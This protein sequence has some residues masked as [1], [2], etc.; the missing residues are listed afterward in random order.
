MSERSLIGP[1]TVMAVGTVT[2]RVTGVLRDITMAAALGFFLVSDAFSLG[3]SLPT[4]IYILVIGG[5]LNAV[6]IPQLVRKMKD[7]ADD[8]K[9]YADRLITITGIALLVLSVMAVVLA[10]LIVDLYT[11]SDYPRQEFDLAVAFARLCLPQIFFYGVYAMLS[12]VL[13]SRGKFGAPM[14]A[15]IANN[16]VAI[17]TFL[18]F[19][20]I[21]GTSAAADGVLTT[22]QVLLLGIGTTLGVV[23]QALILIPVLSRAGYNWRPRF[24]WR[25]HGLGK[26]GY[27]A[28]W[29][30]GLV[31]VNQLTYL[32]ITRFAT[33]ANVNASLAGEVAAGLTTYQKAH[34]VFILPHSVITVSIIT[35]LLPALSRVAHSGKLTQV[36]R[37]IAG[38]MRLVSFFI[39]PITAILFVAG[40]AIA[41]LLFGYGAATT[42]Q[43]EILGVVISIFMLGLIPF[44]LFY[45]LLRGF[46]ALEDTRTPFIITVIFSIVLLVLLVPF[47]GRFSGGGVQISY[48]A[49]CYSISYWVGLVIAWIV[50]ARRVKGMESGKLILSIGRM[51]I[52]GVISLFTMILV[53]GQVNNLMFG[54]DEPIDY[55]NKGLILLRLLIVSVA[56]LLVYLLA[57][58]ALRVPE[59][60]MAQRLIASKLRRKATT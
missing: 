48:I 3:N 26:A 46:Y 45:V 28:M 30:I 60:G 36:G 11:P 18:L 21:A 51:F 31:L 33:Q 6:F 2:S 54:A 53:I 12:Q 10:P 49:L 9:A 42:G 39:I 24:D 52:A 32:V 17:A 19:I 13:N 37:D 57:A 58:W 25:G 47:F 27:L 4:M 5:A 35:A 14:F 38:A 56:G 8:G 7:D 34:L 50:L 41:V 20:S 15:P 40:I 44:T 43:A 16:V 59:I 55:S 23:A 29:T 1:S 22:D